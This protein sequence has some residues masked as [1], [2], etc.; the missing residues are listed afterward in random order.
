MALLFNRIGEA[1]EDAIAV[2]IARI[3]LWKRRWRGVAANGEEVAVML[4]D[5][6]KN[7]DTLHGDER[8]I[9]IEQLEEEVVAITLPQDPEMAAK[10]AWYLG[11]R[12]IPVEVRTTE[13]L[14]ENF[15]TLTDSLERIGIPHI[16]RQDILNCR[17]HSEDHQH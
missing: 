11:N 2:Q 13:L 5:P 1:C 15:P 8:S 7:G 12:H 6:A 3:D 4:E 10:I 14:V 17:P 9:R 16:V